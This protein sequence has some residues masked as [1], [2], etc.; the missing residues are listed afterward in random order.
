MA[1]LKHY[2]PRYIRHTKSK[3]TR[4]AFQAHSAP[5]FFRVASKKKNSEKGRRLTTATRSSGLFSSVPAAKPCSPPATPRRD[6]GAPLR[7]RPC[8]VGESTVPVRAVYARHTSKALLLKE[9]RRH[10]KGTAVAG[11][12]PASSKVPLSSLRAGV[13]P[14]N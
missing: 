14:F 8:V 10:L 3:A 1:S 6:F 7:K 4:T 11:P 12:P 5:L 9:K 13:K 2:T